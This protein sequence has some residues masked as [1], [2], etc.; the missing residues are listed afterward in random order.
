[1]HLKVRDLAYTYPSGVEALRGV[2][3][4][5]GPGERV[6]IIGRNGSGKT[7]LVKHLNGLVKPSRGSVL[8]GDWDTRDH[9][10]A[11]LARRVGFLFQNPDTQIFKSRVWE[12]IAFGPQM[13]R[14]GPNE[15][16]R[17]VRE[18]LAQTGL[19]GQ[20]GEH[21]YEL[22]A[23]QRR[24]VAIAS[25]LA[26]ESPI[27]VLDEPTTGQDARGLERL[28]SMVDRLASNG[29]T[30]VVVTHDLDFCAEHCERVIVMERG[31][32]L[33]D[34]PARELLNESELLLFA[35]AQPPQIIRLA[36]TLGLPAPITTIDEFLRAI[37]N[38]RSE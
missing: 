10:T 38:R 36:L 12:E 31:H 4:D 28:G 15:V 35:G 6:A 33:A 37:E 9:T 11:R 29:R 32:V 8:V 14:L 25:V 27:L 13:L 21:P 7:T 30:V 3:L 26:L 19:E 5:I 18:A 2:S 23:P 1:M 34:G 22:D 24:W 16:D 17:R 20:A